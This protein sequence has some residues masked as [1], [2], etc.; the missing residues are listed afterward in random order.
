MADY[1]GALKRHTVD[2]LERNFGKEFLEAT[3]IDWV[4]TVPAVWS[5]AAKAMTLRA[6][7]AAGLGGG[8]KIRMISEPDAA[9]VCTLRDIQPNSL[10]VD[11]TF[12]VVDCGGG[13]VVCCA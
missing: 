11:D 6:A 1:L 2:T 12:I 10:R 4:M 3:P 8:T 9:A 7:E 5:D 13:T